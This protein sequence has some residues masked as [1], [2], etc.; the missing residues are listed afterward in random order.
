[1]DQLRGRARR[2]VQA[3]RQGTSTRGQTMRLAP[4][5]LAS[6]VYGLVVNRTRVP[7][8]WAKSAPLRI[9][10]GGADNPDDPADHWGMNSAQTAYILL[11]SPFRI[12]ETCCP[13]CC[14]QNRHE[15]HTRSTP[16][17]DAGTPLL[18]LPVN[19]RTRFHGP[20]PG[21]IG[22]GGRIYPD[23]IAIDTHE[24]GLTAAR[25]RGAGSVYSNYQVWRAGKTPAS[26]KSLQAPWRSLAQKYQ[27]A[28]G[29]DRAAQIDAGEPP[30]ATGSSHAGQARTRRNS[31]NRLRARALGKNPRPPPHLQARG[32]SS[33]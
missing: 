13:G 31:P 8:L 2:R 25:G 23:Q 29:V 14:H 16:A 10:I 20:Q 5:R 3:S 24:P 1:M 28:R 7:D 18:L 6:Q 9:N 26:L 4:W 33:R 17:L 21:K 22:A 32:P 15:S 27:P 19:V 30:G 11:R 12:L